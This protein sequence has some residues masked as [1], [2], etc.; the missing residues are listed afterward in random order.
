[1]RI[2]GKAY[3]AGIYEHPTR[4]AEYKSLALL[5]AEVAV[6]NALSPRAVGRGTR[7]QREDRA[8]RRDIVQIAPFGQWRAGRREQAAVERRHTQ[9]AGAAAAMR[10]TGDRLE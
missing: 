5:H 6:G 10:E 3:I 7:R 1:M 8:S 9:R 4:K 2:K